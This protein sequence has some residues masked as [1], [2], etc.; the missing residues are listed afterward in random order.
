MHVE[1]R[2]EIYNLFNHTNFGQPD[3]NISNTTAGVITAADD[4]RN[5][6]F[7]VRIVW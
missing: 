6:Q 7:A 1:F 5:I 2:G 4:A 3:S